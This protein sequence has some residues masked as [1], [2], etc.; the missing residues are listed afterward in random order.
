MIEAIA[1]IINGGVENIPPQEKSFIE[2]RRRSGEKVLED[3]EENKIH[4][5]KRGLVD[6]EI[7]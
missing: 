1:A 3:L 7:L 2:A 6:V 5:D 4:I